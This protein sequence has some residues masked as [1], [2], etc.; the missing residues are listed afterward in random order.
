[1]LL[2]TGITG[3]TGK[4]LYK[5]IQKSYEN[6]EV[7]YLV[8][9]TSDIS[10]LSENDNLVFGDISSV[11]SIKHAF[12]DVTEVLHLAPRNQLLN[13]L[14][15]CE[16]HDINRIYYVNSTGIYSDFKRSSH[17]DL[18]NE[19]L[20]KNSNL[21]YTIIRPTM[22]Y[23]NIQDGNIHILTKIMSRTPIYPIIGSG[24]GLMHP[25]YAGDL[26]KVIVNAINKEELTRFK[27]YN[28]A[29]KEP[30]TYEQLLKEIATAMN[31]KVFF[32]KIPYT[33]A[34]LIGKI[35]DKIPN[36]IIN[37]EKILRLKEDKNFDYSL[38]RT[39]LGFEPLSFKEGIS[40]EIE[41]LKE[42]G[43]I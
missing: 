5:E 35:G 40:L 2:I 10:W 37:H 25:I 23:G 30:I 1:M 19:V 18:R 22:I 20:L 34:L 13:I 27:E 14:K 24:N 43:I 15:V 6:K 36:K 17:V 9:S 3:L 31:K 29:G 39:D 26:A 42:D 21:M 41:A 16:Y 7:K 8:R 12:E 4:F 38:A 28:V 11:D 33:L 32:L